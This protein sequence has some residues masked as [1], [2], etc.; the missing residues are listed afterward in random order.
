MDRIL[1]ALS[2]PQMK[3]RMTAVDDLQVRRPPFASDATTPRAR[4]SPVAPHPR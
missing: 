2:S 1:P 3:S 4:A